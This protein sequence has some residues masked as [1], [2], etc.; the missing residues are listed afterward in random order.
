[1]DGRLLHQPQALQ[2]SG[3]EIHELII[4][5]RPRELVIGFEKRCRPLQIDDVSYTV[6]AFNCC[7]PVHLVI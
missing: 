3:A 5:M 4:T 6:F 1:M 2:S 7:S